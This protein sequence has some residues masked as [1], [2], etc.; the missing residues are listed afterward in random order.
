MTSGN[1]LIKSERERQMSKKG[2]A[3]EHDDEFGADILE[4]AALGYRDA[5]GEGSEIPEN[6]PWDISG[7]KPS[8]RSR[9]LEKAGALYL[10]AAETAERASDYENRNRLNEHV[11]S[12]SNLIDSIL[13]ENL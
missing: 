1:T 5:E 6:W 11:N 10:A 8:I 4:T 9:N 13:R 7:W 3:H 2:W 12:C